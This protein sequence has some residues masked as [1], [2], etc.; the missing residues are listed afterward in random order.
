MLNINLIYDELPEG[1][2][3][4][5]ITFIR[6][7][8]VRGIIYDRDR[9]LMVQTRLGD[10]K[11]PGGGVQENETHEEALKREIAEETGYT[12]VT[13]CCCFGTV[14]EQNIDWFEGDDYFQMR[15][16]YYICRLNSDSRQEGKLE[17]YEQDGRLTVE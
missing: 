4:E 7:T 3:Q 14:F 16:Y 2:R 9:L 10:Y 5:E 15:S 1:K 17:G 13:I 8:A 12:D 11:F 6:R